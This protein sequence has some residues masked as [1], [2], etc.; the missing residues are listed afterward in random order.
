MVNEYSRRQ[1]D[2]ACKRDLHDWIRVHSYLMTSRVQGFFNI[3]RAAKP[4]AYFSHYRR[5]GRLCSL[6]EYIVKHKLL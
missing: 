1:L 6:K 4:L 3:Y 2:F 5:L